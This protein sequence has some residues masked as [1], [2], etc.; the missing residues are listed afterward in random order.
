MK[1]ILLVLASAL[2]TLL[3]TQAHAIF[4]LKLTYGLLGSNPGFSNLY[5]GSTSV[6]SIVP[7]YGLGA[8]AVVHLPLMP[9]GFGLRYEDMGLSATSGSLEF[10]ADY[11]RTAVLVNYRLID[12]LIYLGPIF[13]YGISHSSN[14]I[15][16]TENGTQ[17]SNFTAGSAS[18]YSIGVE[19]GV[20][21]VVFSVGAEV[22]Y[23]DMRW[24]DAKDST[25]TLSN[26]DINMSGTYAKVMLGFGI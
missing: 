8:D 5:N 6:P 18:S 15:K 11:K 13:T 1:K 21:L 4:D 19:A 25:G 7:T 24:K 17:V 9:F 26:R 2:T 3:S 14:N 16:A 12:T 22:G 10:K 20:K 23:E